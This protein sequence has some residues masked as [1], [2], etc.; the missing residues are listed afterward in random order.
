[1][2]KHGNTWQKKENRE[3]SRDS[4]NASFRD[5]SCLGSKQ[6]LY[7]AY[8]T[9]FRGE[10]APDSIEDMAALYLNE[11]CTIQPDGPYFIG[12]Y[13]LGGLIFDMAFR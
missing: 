11:I 7:S 5:A 10:R 2:K 12:G 4:I 9:G 13:S 3:S 1:M 8:P 6:P